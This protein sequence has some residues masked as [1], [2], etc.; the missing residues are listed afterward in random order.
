M[1]LLIKDKNIR[2]SEIGLYDCPITTMRLNGLDPN[3]KKFYNKNFI[4]C[5][6]EKRFEA[7]NMNTKLN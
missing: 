3:D 4:T 1:L 2:I 7:I 5:D 6:I